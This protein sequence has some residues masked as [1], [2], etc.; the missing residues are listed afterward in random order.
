MG[1]YLPKLL[2]AT[3]PLR[4]SLAA[5]RASHV[6]EVVL[7]PLVGVF[8]AIT[9]VVF[10]VR[11]TKSGRLKMSRAGLRTLVSEKDGE[12]QRIAGLDGAEP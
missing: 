4:R 3:R 12:I 10:K 7:A 5:M 11:P 1:E 2:F 9:R 8:T 6:L